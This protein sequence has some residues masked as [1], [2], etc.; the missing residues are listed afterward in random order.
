VAEEKAT[1]ALITMVN[2]LP[3]SGKQVT[4]LN[5][6][7]RTKDLISDVIDENIEEDRLQ[8]QAASQAAMQANVKPAPP[9]VVLPDQ[10]P[11]K[12]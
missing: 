3:T 9:R 6:L 11:S 10:A 2:K 8:K 1:L 7:V 12:K 4:A 5:A